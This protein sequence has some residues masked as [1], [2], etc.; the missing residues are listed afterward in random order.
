MKFFTLITVVV[1]LSWGCAEVEL[2]EGAGA[3]R[4]QHSP[5]P[6]GM[7]GAPGT[8]GQTVGTGGS[9]GQPPA[10]GGMAEPGMGGMIPPVDPPPPPP[11]T[12]M[13]PAEL[14][15]LMANA[16]CGYL[17][18]CEY[19]T[20]LEL[21][22]NEDCAAFMTEQLRAT[23]VERL[24]PSVTNGRIIFDAMA[25]QA[26][27]G[28]FATLPCALNL[29]NLP[30]GCSDGFLGTAAE[31]EGCVYDEEC[32]G[33]LVCSVEGACPGTCI[34]PGALGQPCSEARACS[35]GLSCVRGGCMAS[36][37][38]GEVCGGDDRPPCAGGFFCDADLGQ[39]QG[40]CRTIDQRTVNS[41]DRCGLL[42][43]PFCAEGTSCIP[44]VELF[45]LDFRCR[46]RVGLGQR[47]APGLPEHCQD[48]LFC[49]GTNPEQQDIEGNCRALPEANQPCGQAPVGEVCAY[50]LV[51]ESGRCVPRQS[52]DGA[53]QSE[54]SC[55]SGA[56]TAGACA[57]PSPCD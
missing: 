6:G 37:D 27:L 9:V 38:E 15:P 36:L 10:M 31:G 29:E 16:F 30:T 57:V 53:C 47:C 18:R 23:M 19:A 7:I 5:D 20:L 4:M 8:G 42:G 33:S 28:A 55:Y 25:T 13:I 56:C 40:R 12:P 32:A 24:Q 2:D 21:V 3:P 22:L 50:G 39:E 49:E 54:I 35:A 51:C 34:V 1:A 11:P 26:C 52:L 48:G 43:G 44:E 14:A 17:D 45:N 41:G 46:N